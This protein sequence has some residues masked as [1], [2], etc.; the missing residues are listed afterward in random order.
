VALSASCNEYDGPLTYRS[1]YW[2]NGTNVYCSSG[3]LGVKRDDYSIPVSP[4]PSGALLEH[5]ATLTGTVSTRSAN[6]NEWVEQE[7]RTTLHY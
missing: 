3:T 4:E 5:C 7:L 2:Q 6:A 1:V